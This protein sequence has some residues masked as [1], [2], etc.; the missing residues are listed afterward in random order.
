M[1]IVLVVQP[2][3]LHAGCP[4]D[5]VVGLSKHDRMMSLRLMSSESWLAVALSVIA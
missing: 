3:S 4:Q 5:D 1:L 2:K